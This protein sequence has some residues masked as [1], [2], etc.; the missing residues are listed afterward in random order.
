VQQPEADGVQEEPASPFYR[1]TEEF[2][3]RYPDVE[4]E[5]SMMYPLSRPPSGSQ[6]IAP[7]IPV[8]PSRPAPSV[9]RV[10]YGGVHERS[11]APQG[12]GAQPPVYLSQPRFSNV[13]MHKTGLMNFGVTCYMNSILQCLSGHLLLS[14]LFLTGRFQR[15]LQKDNWK[16]TKG[17]LPEAYATLMS[18]LFKGDVH[19]VRPSTFRASQS[20][21]CIERS[22]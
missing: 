17:I 13:R 19:S 14:D 15:D 9:P 2:L 6:Y 5:Q 7:A 20:N 18:N 3:R 10:S 8:A 11:V 4:A 1:T 22:C 21:L 16:G 12:R